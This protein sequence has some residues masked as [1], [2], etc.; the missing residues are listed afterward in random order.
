MTWPTRW[1]PRNDLLKAQSER[2]SNA[3]PGTWDDAER[4]ERAL[5]WLGREHTGEIVMCPPR[6]EGLLEVR[7]QIRRCEANL[8]TAYRRAGIRWQTG[9]YFA[10]SSAGLSATKERTQ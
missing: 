10:E 9:L 1:L 2:R 4:I 3:V 6:Y 5:N 8:R 7:R